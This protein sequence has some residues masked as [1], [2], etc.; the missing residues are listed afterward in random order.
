MCV[1]L[2][3]LIRCSS[4]AFHLSSLLDKF[5]PSPSRTQ[6][7]SLMKDLMFYFSKGL[8]V[9]IFHDCHYLCTAQLKGR[10]QNNFRLMSTGTRLFFFFFF[11]PRTAPQLA[12]QQGCICQC[13]PCYKLLSK[14]KQNDRTFCCTSA[15]SSDIHLAFLSKEKMIKSWRFGEGR[16]SLFYPIAVTYY[17]PFYRRVL[18]VATEIKS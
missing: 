14:A 10:T 1:Y 8:Q 16:D 2:L 5:L 13:V 7:A 4:K 15:Q 11:S 17:N 12:A 18:S 6:H 9:T 3:S